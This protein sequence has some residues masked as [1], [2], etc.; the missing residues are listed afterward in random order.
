MRIA[1]LYRRKRPVFSFEF[2]PPKTDAG[3]DA[4]FAALGELAQLRPDFVSVTCPLDKPRRPLTFTLV[5]R[6]QR[7]LGITAMAHLVTPLYAR[8]EV[9]AVLERAAPRRDREP[10]RAARR[11]AADAGPARARDFPHA[12][13][14]RTSRAA[15]ASR[16]AAPRTRSATP[17]RATGTATSRAPTARWPRAAS[18]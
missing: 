2:F 9:R 5:A 14:S 7:E 1:E 8:D 4:L 6:I 17:T 3:V 13:T 18:S 10:A 12:S 16:S 15:A 11:P